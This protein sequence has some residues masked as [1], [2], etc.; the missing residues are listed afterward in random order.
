MEDIWLAATPQERFFRQLKLDRCRRIHKNTSFIVELR[1]NWD[2]VSQL[3]QF[4]GETFTEL[5]GI[6][7][8]EYVIQVSEIQKSLPAYSHAVIE[9]QAPKKFRTMCVLELDLPTCINALISE[10]IGPPEPKPEPCEEELPLPGD[11]SY[12]MVQSGFPMSAVLVV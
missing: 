11:G 1:N 4:L 7:M 5:Y 8:F 9:K 2:L 12:P 6:S 10:F 3:H